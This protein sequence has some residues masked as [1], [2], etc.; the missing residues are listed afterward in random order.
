M[1]KTLRKFSKKGKKTQQRRKIKGRKQHKNRK[2]YGGDNECTVGTGNISNVDADTCKINNESFNEK[3]KEDIIKCFNDQAQTN[4]TKDTD[5]TQE[6]NMKKL[7]T[8][9]KKAALNLHTDKGGNTSAF[10]NLSSSYTFL[11]KEEPCQPEPEPEPEEEVDIV[12][13]SQRLN[14]INEIMKNIFGNEWFGRCM[15][16]IPT[17]NDFIK[18]SY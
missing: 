2:T 8:A 7:K 14:I 12:N 16:P 18:M 11:T 9:Y 10:Q 4:F 6:E 17:S 1:G 15:H 3:H 5:F 13:Q